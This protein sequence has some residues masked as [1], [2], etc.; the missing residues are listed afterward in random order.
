MKAEL[1]LK[2]G[3]EGGGAAIHRTMLARG[4]YRFHV[5]GNTL[6]LDENDDE[7]WRRWT[8]EPV[9]TVQ[10]ALTSIDH[11]GLWILLHPISIHP[12]YRAEVWQLVQ[13][14]AVALPH[15]YVGVWRTRSHDW[16]RLCLTEA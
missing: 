3:W 8:A 15:E 12:E 16:R 1:V 6:W 2:L 11:H 9:G 5:E 7:A 4:G 13:E 10:G 14:L